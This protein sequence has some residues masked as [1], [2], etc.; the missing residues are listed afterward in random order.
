M[1]LKQ[2]RCF[3]MVA[4]YQNFARAAEVL[5][6]AQPALSRQIRLLEDELGIQ[7]FD[8]HAR[9][10]TLT[11]EGVLLL[12]RSTFILRCADQMKSDMAALKAFP[13]GPVAL[14]MSPGLASL[15]T[16]PL[17]RRLERWP[18]IQLRVVEDL[19]PALDDLLARG[20]VD[21]AV[22]NGTGWAAEGE[23]SRVITDALC[24]IVPF[25][26]PG[27][28]AAEVDLRQL[29]E[30]PLILTG[31][32]RSGIRRQLELAAGLA[33][34]TIRCSVEVTSIAVAKTL[35]AAGVGWTV[36]YAGAIKDE[37]AGRTLRAIPIRGLRLGRFVAFP[38]AR[39]TS[40]A[41]RL[42]C[43]LLVDVM[44][45]MVLSGEWPHATVAETGPPPDQRGR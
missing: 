31:V 43:G 37:I 2:L 30:V 42:V 20:G 27:M 36:Y 33:H 5:H 21:L 45:D 9:G 14:G 34:V 1:D 23:A 7:L 12:E 15:L 13:R 11:A 39:P 41:V 32:A 3:T 40:N 8:R 6:I 18:D 16:A 19:S 22:L 35:I 4:A 26:E 38:P 10:A 17:V 24:L 44:R 29:H 28:T 25:D